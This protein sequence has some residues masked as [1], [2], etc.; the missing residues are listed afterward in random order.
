MSYSIRVF[1]LITALVLAGTFVPAQPAADAG[2]PPPCEYDSATNRVSIETDEATEIRRNG[3]D[4]FYKF[5]FESESEFRS[6]DGATVDNTDLIEFTDTSDFGQIPILIDASRGPFAPGATPENRGKPEI[7]FHLRQEADQVS[8]L[9]QM[10]YL[11]ASDDADFIVGGMRG[12][13]LN[14]DKDI[15]IAFRTG[16]GSLNIDA[17]RGDD[18]VYLDGRKGT[19]PF[20]PTSD[21]AHSI[22]GNRGEDRFVGSSLNDS[23]DG[24]ASRDSL[25]GGAG[26]DEIYGD[27]GRDRI[28]G[29]GGNDSLGGSFGNDHVIAGA[30]AD[31][32]RGD[33]GDDHLEGSSGNDRIRGHKG[34]DHL[35]GDAGIDVC[36]PGPGKDTKED[37]E[38]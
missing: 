7:E 16:E 37:C 18:Q 8:A 26:I 22:E 23:L 36:H 12:M 17:E 14:R 32:L 2:T 13:K 1:A 29:Q 6:C 20:D 34:N 9:S 19:G 15:D 3:R 10:L 33:D 27:S 35:D 30:G 31:K 4:I 38:R 5:L 25:K 11:E 28:L 24:G 21:Y